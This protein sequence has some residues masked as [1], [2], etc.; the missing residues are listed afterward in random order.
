MPFS[1]SSVSIKD[2]R[3]PGGYRNWA[4]A[5]LQARNRDGLLDEDLAASF[6]SAAPGS[7]GLVLAERRV[8]TNLV[9]TASIGNFRSLPP[10]DAEISN[11]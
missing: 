4:V 8:R 10:I 6:A 5:P 9:E 1:R 7:A 2:L 11:T 3:F